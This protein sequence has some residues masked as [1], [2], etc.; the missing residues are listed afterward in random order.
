[1]TINQGDIYWVPLPV[2]DSAEPGYSHPHVVIQDDA[3]FAKDDRA[4]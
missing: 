4:P 3:L 1:M 2:A